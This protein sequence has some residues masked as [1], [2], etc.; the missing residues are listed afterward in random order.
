MKKIKTFNVCI[1]RF[2]KSEYKGYKTRIFIIKI[3]FVYVHI[4]D[5]LAIC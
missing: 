4:T 1:N 5:M 3:L 2:S